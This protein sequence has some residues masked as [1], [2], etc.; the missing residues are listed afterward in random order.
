MTEAGDG[1]IV[2]QVLDGD[3]EAFGILV[4]RYRI[5][6]GR[7]A[8]AMLGDR[9]AAEDVLQESFISAYR[10][11]GRCRDPERFKSWAFRIVTNR[12]RD[13]LRKRPAI[14]I[15]LVE[16]P[17]KEAADMPAEDSELA[18]QLERAMS[19]LTP[20]QREVFVMKEVEGRS[21]E[22]M[23]ELLD[24]KIDAL[25]MRVMRAKTVL[26]KAMT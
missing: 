12:C 17:A 21:Y 26:R 4:E 23:A 13:L 1:A 11:L 5:E 3:T 8:E 22:E 2:R 15:D 10:S 25:R 18:A 19:R 9:D 20:E 7:V 24:L 14:S 16:V 6:F